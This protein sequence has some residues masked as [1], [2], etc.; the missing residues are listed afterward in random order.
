VRILAVSDEVAENLWTPEV[1]RY[2]PDL[3][4]ACGDVPFDLLAWISNTTEVPLVFVPGNHDPD[5]GGYRHTRRGL[6]LRA[7]IPV[8]PPWPPGSI[9]ADG[10]VVDLAGLRVAGLGGCRRYERGPNQYTERQQH[11]RV[12]RL[13]ARARRHRPAR[14]VDIVITHAPLAGVGDAGPDDPAHHGFQAFHRLVT[15][16]QPRLFLHGHVDRSAGRSEHRLG[17]TRVINVFDHQLLELDCGA[18]PATGGG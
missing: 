2:Q 13:V 3:V 6:V 14:P 12:R 7:G 8:T 17:V 9:N 1:N 5:L 18:V 4:V 16:L 10:R 15:V 11:R